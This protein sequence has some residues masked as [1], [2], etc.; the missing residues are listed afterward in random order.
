MKKY[1]PSSYKIAKNRLNIKNKKNMIHIFFIDKKN[2]GE[3]FYE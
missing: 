2:M 1:L 3:Y